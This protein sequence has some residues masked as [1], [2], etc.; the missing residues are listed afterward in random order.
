VLGTP[1]AAAARVR[2]DEREPQPLSL[3]A[4]R[5]SVRFDAG[6]HEIV[7]LLLEPA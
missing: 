3:G 2:A 1:V 4:G 5:T 7:T 6:P